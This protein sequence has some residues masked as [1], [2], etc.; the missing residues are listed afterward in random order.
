MHIP[1][2]WAQAR[3][4]QQ[5]RLRHGITTQ[6]WGW[7]DTSQ[8]AAQAHAQERAQQA[9][10]AALAGRL[11]GTEPRME[12]LREYS[13]G[14]ATPIREEVLERRGDTVL[15][16]NSY[17]ARCLNTEHVAI[18]DI[19][20]PAA[21]RPLGFPSPWLGLLTVAVLAVVLQWPLPALQPLALALLALYVGLV[22][23]YWWRKRQLPRSSANQLTAEA[24][25][26]V[27][28]RIEAFHARHADWG[29]RIYATPNGLRVIVTHASLRPDDAKVQ[30]L[31]EA[32]SA[33]PLYVLLCNKQQCFRAR[34]SGKPW[35]MGLSGL[36]STLR[37]W[38]LP[39]AQHPARRQWAQHYDEQAQHYAACRLALHLGPRRMCAEA[40]AFV[41][42]HDAAC[43][44][45][46]ELPLA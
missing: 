2:Y 1:Q 44:A 33:D 25:K 3:L 17:G 34:V 18:A 12:R 36:S 28:R 29:L 43:N 15:T 16:R 40:Q 22:L 45:C 27:L 41:E 39:D 38:P 46:S 23:R 5:Q 10:D 35:R 13:L 32:L 8:E 30:L 21:P 6:R 7:S 31:F 26:D 20:L 19:D 11:P 24:T 37:R 42:W 9:L 4:R 14:G